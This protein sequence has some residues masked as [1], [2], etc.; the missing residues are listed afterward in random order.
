VTDLLTSPISGVVVVTLLVLVLTWRGLREASG[1]RAGGSRWVL[2]VLLAVF[3]ADVLARFAL[4][5]G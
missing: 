4:L 2:V 3:A 1:L 5:S